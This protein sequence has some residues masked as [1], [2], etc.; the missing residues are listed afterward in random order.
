MS[1]LKMPGVDNLTPEQDRIL[2]LPDE[3]R[4]FVGGPPGTGKTIVAL[5]RAHAMTARDN[6]PVILM[7]NKLL[8]R[9]CLQWLASRKLRL[10]VSTWNRWFP[11]HYARIYRTSP[12]KLPAQGTSGWQPY[13]W[14]QIEETLASHPSP[15]S[16]VPLLIDEGQDLPRAFYQYV[17]LHFDHV[18]V[19]ADE[20]QMLDEQQNSTKEAIWAEL[21]IPPEHRYVL[22]SN[23]RNT[24]EIAKVA[25]HFYP[26]TDAGRPDMPVRRG[27]T[28]QLVDYGSVARV[29]NWIAGMAGNRRQQLIGVLTA[30]N[31]SQDA[32]RAALEPACNQANIRFS[33]YRYGQDVLV[34]FDQAG[35]V[36]L[37]LQSVKGLEFDSVLIAD[38]HEHHIH[39]NGLAHKMRL[40]VATSRA[41]DRLH[42]L[43]H[44]DNT[45]R[46]LTLMPG[47]DILRRHTLQTEGS[48]P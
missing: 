19:F 46:L 12:P 26:G 1:R 20:N 42:L 44:R 15:K 45:C 13:D 41:R 3:G 34:N 33:W 11:R 2:R 17:S 28:P 39:R 36:L 6:Q 27:D 30:N 37:N 9:Y 32:L 31:K 35:V 40:Y 29:A 22:T 10:P 7:H 23:H 21:S 4:H 38:L 14:P 48:A 8:E 16:S 43:H 25:N 5:L 18:T 47:E 24:L